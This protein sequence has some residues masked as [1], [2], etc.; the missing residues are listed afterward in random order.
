MVLRVCD[1][2]RVLGINGDSLWG[3]ELTRLIAEASQDHD[4]VTVLIEGLNA[5]IASIR[6]VEKMV[7]PP[8]QAFWTR[9]GP[10]VRPLHTKSLEK[11]TIPPEDLDA[12]IVG[13]GHVQAA[14]IVD[15]DAAGLPELANFAP[16]LTDGDGSLVGAGFN[17]SLE[18]IDA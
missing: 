1:I 11:T 9:Q 13:I 18:E 14:R 17:S 15:H 7:R 3:I 6:N 10:R 16:F 2:Q 8:G 12:M 5:M 4:G